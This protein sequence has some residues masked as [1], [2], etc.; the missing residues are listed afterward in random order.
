MSSL[1]QRAGTR[2]ARLALAGASAILV[3]GLL[4]GA[5][6][7]FASGSPPP[8]S[9]T[10]TG[11]APSP[12]ADAPTGGLRVRLRLRGLARRADRATFQVRTR[13][14]WVTIEFARGTV[15][16]VAD[17]ELVVALPSGASV[18]WT[19]DGQ[20]VVRI[21][22]QKASLSTLRPGQHV[23]VFGTSSS[24]GTLTARLI[25]VPRPAPAEPSAPAATPSPV[26]TT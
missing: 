17:G 23:A 3:A 12:A 19:T 13:H 20:T 8:A 9:S 18:T 1:R 26:P 5:S 11:A 2:P 21:D 16:R 14:G 22:G 7:T 10:L 24:G 6:L 15:S 25:R 4:V